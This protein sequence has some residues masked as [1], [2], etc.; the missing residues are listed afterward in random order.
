ML[1]LLVT[2]A[3]AFDDAPYQAALDRHLRDGRVDYAAIRA[4]GALDRTVAALA[5]APEPS[6]RAA[7]TAFWINAYNA[8]TIDMIADAWPVKS[9]KDIAGGDPWDRRRFTVAGRELTL[10]DIEHK[11][12]R[13]L[14]DPRVH[15]ALNCASLGCPPLSPRAFTAAGLSAELDQA[16]RAWAGS[17]ALRF[18]LGAHKVELSSIFDWYGKD[19][20]AQSQRDLPGVSGKQEAAL[21]FL[22]PWLSPEQQAAVSAGGL[23]V[24]YQRYDWGVNGR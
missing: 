7:K 12:L 5:A 10:N 2:A 21:N 23:S 1:L 22:F 19:F 20:E 14:G 18:D 3:L 4:S 15:A 6:D 17:N 11:T 9:I 16:A 8:L 24:S 13:P